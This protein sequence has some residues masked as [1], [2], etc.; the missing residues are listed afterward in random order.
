MAPDDFMEAA[1][2]GA[3]MGPTDKN[4]KVYV[5]GWEPNGSNGGKFYF[6]HLSREQQDEFIGLL[7]AKTV[8]IGYPGYFYTL[9]YFA[10]RVPAA[11]PAAV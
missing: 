9:P 5:N 6:Q 7:N 10:V 3:E 4:Y 2:T 1:R 11:P 8:H